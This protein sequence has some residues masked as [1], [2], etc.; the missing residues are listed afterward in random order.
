MMFE[1]FGFTRERT[2]HCR[3]LSQLPSGGAAFVVL[4]P[5]S[6]ILLFYLSRR[7]ASFTDFI[8][9][10]RKV[11]GYRGRFLVMRRGGGIVSTFLLHIYF[12]FHYDV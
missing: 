1:A 10:D 5:L 4:D 8:L 3:N 9:L 7:L 2:P 11:S 12:P 6:L